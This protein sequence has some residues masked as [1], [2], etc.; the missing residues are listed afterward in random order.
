MLHYSYCSRYLVVLCE[1]EVLFLNQMQG[2]C[3][4]SVSIVKTDISGIFRSFGGQVNWGV[5]G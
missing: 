2:Q 5:E 4:N 3:A 1:F